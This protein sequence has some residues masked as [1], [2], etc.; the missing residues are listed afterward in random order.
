MDI[1]N[2]DTADPFNLRPTNFFDESGDFDA[3]AESADP[4]EIKEMKENMALLVLQ[5]S[6]SG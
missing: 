6:G 3:L 4:K 1:F 5:H 2:F